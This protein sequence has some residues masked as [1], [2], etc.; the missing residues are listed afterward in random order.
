MDIKDFTEY[1]D[2]FHLIKDL[3]DRGIH[4]KA[5]SDVIDENGF[6]YVELVQEGGGVLG[7]ALIGYTYVLEQMGLRFL[8]LAGTSA[9]S[10]NTILL[11]SL[12]KINEPKSEKLITLLADKNLFDFGDGGPRVKSFFNAIFRNKEKLKIIWNGLKITNRI[13]K[14]LG[15]NPGINFLDWLTEV[16]GSE[17]IGS[18]RDL[19]D[20]ISR[21]PSG[22]KIR[23][24]IDRSISGLVPRLAIITA[25]VTTETKVEFPKMG[26]LYWNNPEEVNPAVYVRASMSI[27]FFFE[28]LKVTNIPSGPDAM[29]KWNELASYIGEIPYEVRF[30]DGGIMSNFP[31]DIFHK[32]HVV[33]RLPTFGAKLG[34]DRNKLNQIKSPFSLFGAI[35]NSVRHLHDYDFILRN[36][37]YKMLVKQIDIGDHNWLNF[38]LSDEAKKDLFYRGAKA[39]AEFLKDFYWEK[40]KEIRKNIASQI[41][42]VK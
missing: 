13:F 39:A 21:L 34:I 26:I 12:G 18:T 10:I 9:G 37:D 6:Q 3:K 35:F 36:K 41:Y 14:Y 33:P 31:I 27:P 30:V 15:L 24:G 4:E 28:P 19:L 22:L 2:V 38:N 32:K 1:P 40:Y 23:T 5:F 20:R 11:A 17:G 7:V 29:N 8:G 16:I 42:P 25:D